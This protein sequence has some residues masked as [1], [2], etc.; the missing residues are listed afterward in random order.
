MN[1]FQSPREKLGRQGHSPGDCLRAFCSDRTG[2]AVSS[3]I[4]VAPL[5]VMELE[6]FGQRGYGGRL[7]EASLLFLLGGPS[8]YTS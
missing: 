3:M 8:G 2:T 7:F 4:G 5:S 6:R 1:D